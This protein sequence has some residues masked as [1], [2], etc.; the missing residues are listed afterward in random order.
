[1]VMK[2]SIVI[3]CR[4]AA[5]TL[6]LQLDALLAQQWHGDW[7][8]IV[9]DNG[10]NDDSRSVAASYHGRVPGLRVVD[11]SARQGAAHARNCGVRESKGDF[12]AFCDADDQVG[13]GWLAAIAE[14]LARD[15]LVASRMD[16]AKL[17]E[18]LL[19]GRM[20]RSQERGLQRIG[21][22]PYWLHAGGSGLG[23]RRAVHEQVG[24][25]DESLPFLEDTDYCFR[26]QQAGYPLVF[27]T[28]ACIH[29]RIRPNSRAL[30]HQA[31]S[32]AQYNV[33]MNRRY[34]RGDA[35]PHPWKSHVHGWRDLIGCLPRLLSRELRPAWLKSL[36]TQI[37]LL[38]GA[39]RYRVPPVR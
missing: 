32:W 25:F 37:G 20:S 30:F 1:M 36:G 18:R 10:S 13:A 23:V 26:I 3:P 11:A 34:G 33:L 27:V 6:P 2:L 14:A 29:V 39:L 38:E 15:S 9:A 28:N 24:G 7:E 19:D 12:I 21:Y 22:P 17:N 16:Y 8:V 35:I 5:A 4:N 31:R